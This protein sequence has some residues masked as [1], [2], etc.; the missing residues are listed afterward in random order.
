MPAGSNSANIDVNSSYDRLITVIVDQ[1]ELSGA[2]GISARQISSLAGIPV[3]SIYHHFGSLEHL[4]LVAQERAQASAAAW[5]DAQSDAL[6]DVSGSLAAFAPFFSQITDDW[7]QRQRRLAF[8]WREGQLLPGEPGDAARAGWG[9]VWSKFW[10]RVADH[11]ALGP[12]SVIA[13][14]AFENE[15]FLHMCD[16][17]RLNDRAALDEFG[18]GLAAWM[19]GSPMPEAPWREAARAEAMRNMPAISERDETTTTIVKAAAAIIGK[20][21]ITG[22]THRSVA[23]ATGLTLGLVS[24][25]FRTKSA[26]LEAAYEELYAGIVGLRQ[27]GGTTI[28]APAPVSLDAVVEGIVA[29]LGNRGGDELV[30]AAARDPSLN[31]FAAQLRY[32]RGRTAKGAWEA[33]LE[34]RRPV[35]HLEAALVSGVISSQIRTFAHVAADEARAVVRGELGMLLAHLR[36]S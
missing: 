32:L 21:G 34:G 25:K 33:L 8:A 7:A 2:S 1:W 9:R 24:Y 18:R 4:F 10:N 17:R 13:E 20:S 14:R 11:F 12:L 3:S 22:L 29:Q 30:I 26:L 6:A 31:Q 27:A 23:E 36:E 16:W 28:A 19:N 5:C 35:S 15:S